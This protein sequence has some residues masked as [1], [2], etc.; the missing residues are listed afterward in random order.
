MDVWIIFLTGL[1]SGG[2]ACMAVQGGLLASLLVNLQAARTYSPSQ[3]KYVIASFLTT[4]LI[5]HILLGFGLGALGSLVTLSLGVR[6]FFQVLAAVFMLATAGNLLQL[7]PLFRWVSFQPP[8]FLRRWIYKSSKSEHL[9]APIILGALTIF[10]PCGVTQSIEVLAVTTGS[11]LSGAL[12]M[13]AFVLG[14]MPLF[15]VLGFMTS[16]ASSR[17]ETQFARLAAA[18]LIGMSVWSLNGVLIVLDSPVTVQKIVAPVTWFFSDQRFSDSSSSTVTTQKVTIEVTN[19]G[20][21]P[22]LVTVQSGQE[23]ELTVQSHETYSCA[24][25][26]VLKEFD[27]SIDLKPTDSQVVRF[28]PQKP[29]NYTFTCSMGM[30]TGTLRVL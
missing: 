5:M 28:T 12:M 7:H 10:I 26:F 27:I 22:S 6:L 25:S 21:S 13:G 30:Y 19:S 24:L 18:I 9:F 17:F 15:A 14:T 11:P 4:K 20:Y 23:V 1:T 3:A 8:Q 16:T 2:I 29:G